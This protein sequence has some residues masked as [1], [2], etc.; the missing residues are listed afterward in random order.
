ML[1]V[2]YVTYVIAYWTFYLKVSI[3]VKDTNFSGLLIFELVFSTSQVL[4]LVV[5]FKN[6]QNY[7]P[8]DNLIAQKEHNR[9]SSGDISQET[10]QASESTHDHELISIRLDKSHH[11]SNSLTPQFVDLGQ[12]AYDRGLHLLDLVGQSRDK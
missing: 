5:I 6:I 8:S 1:V 12:L 7:I 3:K 11:H 4:L 9:P 10:D 2:S